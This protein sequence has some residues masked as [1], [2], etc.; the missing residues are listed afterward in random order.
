MKTPSEIVHAVMN[1]QPVTEQE[2]KL[3]LIT[4]S[5]SNLNRRH[6]DLFTDEEALI[7]LHRE[8]GDTSILETLREKHDLIG[9]KIGNRYVYHRK[10]LDN[11]VIRLAGIVAS[12]I[13]RRQA[14]K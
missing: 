4:Y 9:F 7:Y 3:A 11:L 10:H 8:P 1:E 6:P 14:A 5:Q 2:L 12:P 13:K